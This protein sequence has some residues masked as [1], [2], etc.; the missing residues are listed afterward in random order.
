MEAE[1][2]QDRN[3]I[4]ANPTKELFVFMLVRDITLNDAIGDLVDNSVDGAKR[5]RPDK[6]SH[7]SRS[8]LEPDGK[9]DG[10]TIEVT[11]KPDI[12]SII[13]NCGGIPSDIAREYAFRFG[14]PKGMVTTPGS[15]GQFGI[16]MKR[17]LFKL[18]NH[19]V[20]ESTSPNSKFLIEEDITQW[21]N[22]ENWSFHFKELEENATFSTQGTTIIIEQLHSDVRERFELQNFVNSLRRE[23]EKEQLYNIYRGLSI[24]INGEKLQ[25]NQLKL[26]QSDVF[27]TAHWEKL[28][29]INKNLSSGKLYVQIFAGVSEENS[30]HG[31]WYIF[32]NDRLILANDQSET[33]GWGDK[34][35]KY[36]TQYN[37]FRGYV[38]F[39]SENSDLLPWTTTKNAMDID[40]PYFQNVRTQMLILMRPVINFLNKVHDE[41][42]KIS[43]PE[44]RVL[45]KA[46]NAAE[47]VVLSKID[48]LQ[49][50]FKYP[51][52]ALVTDKVVSISYKKPLKDV[53]KAKKFFEVKT[54]QDAGSKTFDYWLAMEGEE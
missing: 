32:C 46:L 23:I 49:P 5:L 25:S 34:I 43:D 42:Q 21:V 38:F 52:Q 41:R 53:E 31:G 33:T 54:N 2:K 50:V 19:F 28:Y 39:N 47:S 13:D 29:S 17:A 1:D 30:Q 16:G 8:R 11:A 10:L 35:P 40:N 48:N 51:E 18:G 44:Q 7:L 9:Y 24:M 3:R 22:L 12:F 37:R 27:Y 45:A 20:I 15:V 6:D 4:E 36:H 14:R 26:L